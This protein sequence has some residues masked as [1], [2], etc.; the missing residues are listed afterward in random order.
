MDLV[1]Y[2]FGTGVG[3]V[4]I[5]ESPPDL[6]LGGA[7]G[8]DAVALDFDGDGW[9]DDALWDRDGDGRADV[10]VLDVGAD[11]VRYFTD[12]DGHGTWAVEVPYPDAQTGPASVAGHVSALETVAAESDSGRWAPVDF[13]DDGSTDDTA[14]D[15]DGDGVPNAVVVSRGAAAELFVDSDD[16]GTMDLRLVDS[17]GDGRVDRRA[18]SVVDRDA[19]SVVEH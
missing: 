11:T 19:E 8:V 12:P 14:V 10:S 3:E 5:W 6:D 2:G 15:T 18:D 16:D 13:T 17:D 1:E 4:Q 9:R 7:G